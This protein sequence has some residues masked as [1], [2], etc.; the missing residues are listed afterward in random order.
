MRCVSRYGADPPHFAWPLV[1]KCPNRSHV[2]L[3]SL[4]SIE[5]AMWCV[6]FSALLPCT[7]HFLFIH[8]R[9]LGCLDSRCIAFLRLMCSPMSRPPTTLT[10]LPWPCPNFESST[11]SVLLLGAS[12]HAAALSD[13]LGRRRQSRFLRMQ[14]SSVDVDPID[15]HAYH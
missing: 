10:W 15:A 7:L 8:T 9:S 2:P 5:C 6:P 13:T 1:L 12:M 11:C 3:P 14:R 4:P